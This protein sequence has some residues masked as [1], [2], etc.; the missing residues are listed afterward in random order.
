VPEAPGGGGHAF[1]ASL[2]VL[3]N[4]LEAFDLVHLAPC[5]GF[6]SGPLDAGVQAC[7]AGVA[8]RAY[9][10]YLRADRA[11]EAPLRVQLALPAGRWRV[12]TLDPATGHTISGD[13]IEA[14][15]GA[16]VTLPPF[17]V[18]LVVRLAAQ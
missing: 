15:G 13:V 3:K 8:G 11:L 4:F 14:Q 2:A 1:R 7:A 9:G 10:V 17:A 6:V 16:E 5:P 18:D 12:E